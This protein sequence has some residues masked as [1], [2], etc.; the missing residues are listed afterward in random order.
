MKKIIS[1]MLSVVLSFCAVSCGGLSQEYSFEFEEETFASV[2]KEKIDKYDE[3][4]D[5]HLYKW[6]NEKP[7]G[8]QMTVK[9]TGS[10]YKRFHTLMSISMYVH[11]N[12]EKFG[13]LEIRITY[14]LDQRPQSK[15]DFYDCFVGGYDFQVQSRFVDVYSRMDYSAYYYTE[16]GRVW[17]WQSLHE[18]SVAHKNGYTVDNFLSYLP[19][20]L[21]SKYQLN[22]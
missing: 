2:L 14:S 9:A 3:N 22:V 11:H 20:I 7:T 21:K 8:L 6:G 16:N 18:S 17:F 4:W 12:D 19:E 10:T 1:L 15:E 5:F 13:K